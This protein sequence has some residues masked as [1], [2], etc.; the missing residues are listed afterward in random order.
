MET[1]KPGMII[2]AF[3]EGCDL[4]LR[5]K[6]VTPDAVLAVLVQWDDE[7]LFGDD[8]IEVGVPDRYTYEDLKDAVVVKH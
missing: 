6:E 8:F 2:Y 4:D 5:V 3:I 7:R 1:F